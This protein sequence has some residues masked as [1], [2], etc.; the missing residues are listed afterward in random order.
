MRNGSPKNVQYCRPI[1]K[2]RDGYRHKVAATPTVEE[3]VGDESARRVDDVAA[4]VSDVRITVAFS[5]QRRQLV[6]AHLTASQ[7]IDVLRHHVQSMI[8]IVVRQPVVHVHF[9][10]QHVKSHRQS[11]LQ[12]F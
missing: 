2:R 10:L 7:L 12:L 3:T 6:G 9:A 1:C 11:H 8:L 4:R 5:Q